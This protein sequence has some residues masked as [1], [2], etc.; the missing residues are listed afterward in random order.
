[1]TMRVRTDDAIGRA[2]AVSGTW[3]PN[4]TKVFAQH[5]STGD[6]CLDIGAH[7]GYYTLLAS[8]LVGAQGHVYAFEPSPANFRELEHN[9]ARNGIENVTAL[10]AA[11][12]MARD[13]VILYEGPGTNTG[14]AT[15]R[16]ELAVA[17]R[18]ARVDVLPIAEVVPEEAWSRIRLVKID[19][20]GSEVDVLRSLEP[21][22]TLGA[23]LAVLLEF[24]AGWS[25]DGSAPDY[26]ERLCRRAGFARHRLMTGYTLDHF[27]PSE[28]AE[29]FAVESI[30]LDQCD[31]LLTR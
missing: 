3:E 24:T 23:P 29:P 27:F 22:F 6:V 15:L 30:P 4:V 10:N 13:R 28:L 7:I 20:E 17:E 26:V 9:L 18:Q 1:M 16:R 8:R 25:D 14:R 2:L 19:V 12:G 21:V 5:L 11:V 31:L